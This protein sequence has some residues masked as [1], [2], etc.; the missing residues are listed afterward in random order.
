MK[1]NH[2]IYH[3]MIVLFS[4]LI[5]FGV[6]LLVYSLATGCGTGSPLVHIVSA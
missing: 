2:S 1:Q 5:A 3:V 6:F 4:V